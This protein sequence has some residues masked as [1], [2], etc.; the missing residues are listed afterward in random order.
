MI[1]V[2]RP[3]WP[4]SAQLT[5]AKEAMELTYIPGVDIGDMSVRPFSMADRLQKKSWGK[6]A[7][8]HRRAFVLNSFCQ[9]SKIIVSHQLRQ[10]QP[11][12]QSAGEP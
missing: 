8:H 6:L 12:D 2:P 10:P 1:R 3:L 11:A 9:R 5:G 4:Q 7:T